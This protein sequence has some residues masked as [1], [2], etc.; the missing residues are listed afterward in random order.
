MKK[1]L[2]LCSMLFFIVSLAGC[3]SSPA[4]PESEEKD[5]P[6]EEVA[7][8]PTQGRPSLRHLRPWT[9]A[10][11]RE[12]PT[13][14]DFTVKVEGLN[15]K[16]KVFL[17]GVYAEQNFIADS[18]ISKSDGSVTFKKDNGY[19]SGMY[20]VGMSDNMYLQIILDK[21]QTFTFTTTAQN[22]FDNV[23]VKG[24]IDTELLYKANKFD[25][26]LQPQ[27]D[28]V[29]KKVK[30]ASFGSE[31]WKAAKAEQ[32]ALI[33]QR[34]NNILGYQQKY[35]EAFYPSF[36]IAG[37]NPNIDPPYLADGTID[38][39]RY[40]PMYRAAFW[41]GVDFSDVRLLRTPVFHNK[42]KR[43]M[44]EL[45]PQNPDSLT[46]SAVIVS[47]KALYGH[48]EIFKHV[49]NWIALNFNEK[50][51]VMGAEKVFVTM[52]KEY[53]T[54][55]LGF[56]TN[57]TSE[58]EKIRDKAVEMQNSLLGMKGMDVTAMDYNDQTHS[59]Y[60]LKDSLIVLFIYSTECDHCKEASPKIQK[61]HQQWKGTGKVG[62]FGI[63]IDKDK[64]E[65]RQFAEKYGFTFT[66]V[67]DPQYKSQ[68][69]LK[70]HMDITPEIYVLDQDR[71]IVGKNLQ[72]EQIPDI[73]ERHL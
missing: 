32:K 33:D 17:Y 36:K 69:Y 58:L 54:N 25:K 57:D 56:W 66:N 30:D 70:Y 19:L 34:L 29:N 40:V 72:P 44:K 6:K 47:E 37:Q 22:P 5:S 73:I 61:L 45:T 48:P 42:L 4:P 11:E 65:F 41:E 26:E 14:A 46:K 52:A 49:V 55:D 35:P 63:C 21:D 23:V 12:V 64:D 28:A 1:L 59:L 62:F 51:P 8:T 50:G 43:Y 3:K 67:Y 18:A 38:Q 20:Y 9:F 10:T 24:N 39:D 71:I 60:D 7:E 13:K 16:K 15:P 68:Y 27:F 31:A 2:I 53:F